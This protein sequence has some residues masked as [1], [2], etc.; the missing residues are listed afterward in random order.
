MFTKDQLRKRL[1]VR[2]RLG[3][4]AAEIPA[5]GKLGPDN[6][7][8]GNQVKTKTN[9]NKESRQDALSGKSACHQSWMV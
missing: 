7:E 8:L 3:W 5:I 9:N 1:P 6:W 4:P 2:T